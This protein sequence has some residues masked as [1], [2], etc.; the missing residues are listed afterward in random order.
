[1]LDLG[2]YAPACQTRPLSVGRA[3][4]RTSRHLATCLCWSLLRQSR[5]KRHKTRHATSTPATMA[6]INCIGCRFRKPPKSWLRCQTALE[7]VLDGQ[8]L[9]LGLVWCLPRVF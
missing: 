3:W 8:R 4:I 7:G 2:I 5:L 6:A 1:M 9:A